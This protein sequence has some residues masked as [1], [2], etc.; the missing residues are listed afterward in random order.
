MP[1]IDVIGS[2]FD[3][4]DFWISNLMNDSAEF[5]HAV[6]NIE[7]SIDRIDAQLVDIGVKKEEVEKVAIPEMIISAELAAIDMTKPKIK[8]KKSVSFGVRCWSK[9]LGCMG[10]RTRKCQ[11]NTIR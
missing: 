10:W 3:E 8:L 5:D 6:K 1:K 2:M 11:N 7:A 9:H 4:N